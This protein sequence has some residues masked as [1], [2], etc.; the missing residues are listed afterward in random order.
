MGLNSIKSP[1]VVVFLCSLDNKVV[2][3][4][5]PLICLSYILF[6]N[7]NMYIGYELLVNINPIFDGM[8][9][10]C[11]PYGNHLNFQSFDTK[12]RVSGK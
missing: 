8:S 1:V 11:R 6:F 9:H 7:L 4:F 5:N 12:S 2:D 3:L 10:T